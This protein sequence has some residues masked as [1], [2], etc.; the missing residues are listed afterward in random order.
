VTKDPLLKERVELLRTIPGIGQITALTWALEIVDP[1][2]FPSI[3]KAVSYAGLCSAHNESAGKVKRGPISKMRNKYLQWVLIEAA[4]IAPRYNIQL[5]EV[6]RKELARGNRNSAT[7]AVARK[8]V[9][10]LLSVD[11]SRQPFRYRC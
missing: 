11:K 3:R 10:Y 4:K 5:A 1:H 9:A 8:M 2:R 6:H 7:I